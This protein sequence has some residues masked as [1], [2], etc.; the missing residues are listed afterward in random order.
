MKTNSLII[1]SLLTIICVFSSCSKY[2]THDDP[3]NVTDANWWKTETNATNALQSVYA[4]LPDGATGRQVMFLSS[5]TDAAVARQDT[6]GAYEIYG[7]GLQNSDWDVALHIWQDDYKDIRRANRFLENVDGCYMDSALKTRY[8]YE[9]RAMRA[10]YHM[11]IMLFF[12]GIPIVKTSLTPQKSNLTR[13]TE[14]EVYEFIVSELTECA[15]HLPDKYDNSEPWRISSGVCWALISRLALYY[16]HYDLARDAA[17]KVID[18]GIYKLY[19]SQDPT[20]NSYSELFSYAGELNN[21]RIFFKN[22]GSSGAW[23]T[24][25]PYGVGGE[26]IISPTNVIVNSYETLQGKT[27]DELGSDSE[28]IYEKDPDYKNN[29]DPRLQATILYPGADYLGDVLDP[30]DPSGNSSDLIGRQFSTAT[31]F[32]NKKYLDPKDRYASSRTL[33][34][35]IIRYAEVL[36]NYVEALEELGDWQNP[37]VVKYLNDIRERAGM[38]GVDVSVYNTQ[39]KMRTLIRRERNV[40]L[41]FEGVHYFDIRRWGVLGDV[42]NGQ[43]YG[44]FNTNTGLPVK[45]EVRS[46]NPDRDLHWPIPRGELLANPKM[47]QNPGY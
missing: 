34:F 44:A 17:K 39:D 35:M 47:K 46:N 38:P 7:T 10:Y 3:I 24:F 16:K 19:R 41:A 1:I 31:G 5:L 23:N 20:V 13:N 2:L 4:G 14:Q 21:E 45:V 27:L 25:A 32:W 43:V 26:T 12:G 30:F 18:Q 11:E 15:G 40:E 33:D 8:K 22:N 29:R 42:M 9:A 37:D 28:A 36:L 6:R